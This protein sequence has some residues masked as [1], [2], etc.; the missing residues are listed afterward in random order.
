M[1]IVILSYSLVRGSAFTSFTV[2]L[3]SEFEEV[4]TSIAIAWASIAATSS[5][6][7]C[8]VTAEIR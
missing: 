8:I 5:F 2:A 4:A 3:D 1:R 6:H 7:Q